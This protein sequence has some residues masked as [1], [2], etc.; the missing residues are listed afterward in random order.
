MYSKFKTILKF[1]KVKITNVKNEKVLIFSSN[2]S[3]I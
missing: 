2:I 3:Y 1:I